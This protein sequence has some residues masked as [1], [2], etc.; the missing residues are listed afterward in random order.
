MALD[1]L[2]TFGVKPEKTYRCFTGQGLVWIT[3]K[4]LA[5]KLID[6]ELTGHAAMLEMQLELVKV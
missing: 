2:V 4:E 6:R 3:F 5:R 1:P